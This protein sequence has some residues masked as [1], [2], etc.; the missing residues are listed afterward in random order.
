MTVIAN[1]G[2]GEQ[3]ISL[4]QE[5]EC[6]SARGEYQTARFSSGIYDMSYAAN[7]VQMFHQTIAENLKKEKLHSS[8]FLPKWCM[9]AQNASGVQVALFGRVD[10]ISNPAGEVRG[11]RWGIFNSSTKEEQFLEVTDPLA[12]TFI[13]HSPNTNRSHMISKIDKNGNSV[14]KPAPDHYAMTAYAKRFC[15]VVEQ[16]SSGRIQNVA[17]RRISLIDKNVFLDDNNWAVTLVSARTSSQG[18]WGQLLGRV[19]GHAMLACE[20]VEQEIP[21]LKY[22]HLTQNPQEKNPDLASDEAQIEIFDRETSLETINGPTWLRP[23]NLVKNMFSFVDGMKNDRVKFAFYGT[24]FASLRMFGDVAFASTSQLLDIDAAAPLLL[25][26]A[27]REA[28]VPHTC[29]Q[30]ASKIAEKCGIIFARTKSLRTPIEKVTSLHSNP[31]FSLPEGFDR[32]CLGRAFSGAN[33]ALASQMLSAC[34][35]LTP[36]D[37]APEDADK[38]SWQWT[39]EDTAATDREIARIEVATTMSDVLR[40]EYDPKFW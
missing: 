14:A 5:S 7:L 38:W 2:I 27:R 17:L 22:V 21:F 3:A 37:S 8:C 19:T 31:V 34:V 20:G 15:V 36:F 12:R 10:T 32:S 35:V 25:R 30:W 4:L 29:L 33:R 16:D 6:F 9:E 23:K 39:I 18:F 24:F 13:H 28:Q 26:I 11:M 40:K 1:W